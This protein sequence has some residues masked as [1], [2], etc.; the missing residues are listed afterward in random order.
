MQKFQIGIEPDTAIGQAPRRVLRWKTTLAVA[1]GVCIFIGSLFV[2]WR[3]I[4]T[5][6]YVETIQA[7]GQ[8]SFTTLAISFVLM[9]FGFGI[10]SFEDATGAP[11]PSRL[12]RSRRI[13]LAFVANAVSNITTM[14][15]LA[16]P[17]LRDRLFSAWSMTPLDLARLGQRNQLSIFMSG[18]ALLVLS[19]IVAQGE[20]S[21]ELKVNSFIVYVVCMILSATFV[22]ISRRRLS[23][24][25]PS[26][27]WVMSSSFGISLLLGLAKWL[28]AAGALYVCLGN[29]IGHSLSWF[30]AGFV[31]AHSLGRLSGLP[32]GIGVFEATCFV[33][34]V[35]TNPVDLMVA[36]IAY[37]GLYF[38]TPLI[39]SAVITGFMKARP[40]TGQVARGSTKVLDVFELIAPPLYAVLIF[41]TGG[42][43]LISAATP[44]SFAS[45]PFL[46]EGFSLAVTE[47]SHLTA[48]FIGSL[49]LIVAMGLRRRLKNAWS[50]A[51]IF[52]FAGAIFTLLKGADPK[53][54]FVLLVLCFSLFTSKGAFYR[55]GSI[56]DIPL[57]LPRLGV[58]LTTI[59]FAIWI[60]FFSYLDQPYK[61]DLWWQFG[62][63]SDVSR[64]FRA[65][66][67][68][69]TLFALYGFWRLLQPAPNLRRATSDDSLM[70]RIGA[71]L[72][73]AE[74]V[75]SDA[76]LA[77]MG[78]KQFLFSESGKSF[79]MYGVKGRTWVVMGNP[80]GLAAE[81]KELIW[82]FRQLADQ[83]DAWPCF[84]AVRGDDL[85]DFIDAGLALQ[86]IGEL[87]LIS[88][89]DF[90][91]EGKKRSELRNSK[92]RA[93][94]E[95][96]G[97]EI[98]YPA[99][100]SDDMD[101]LERISQNWLETHQGKEKQFS[102]GRFDRDVLSRQPVAVV[103]RAGEIIAFANLWTTH[104]KTEVSIDLMRYEDVKINGLMDYLFTEIILWAKAE[105]YARFSLGM[106]PLAGLEGDKLAPFMTKLGALIFEHG[107]RFYGFKGL[108]AFK[109]KFMPEW[110]PVYIAAPSQLTMP[111]A[112]GNL[113]LLSS[114][115]ILGLIQK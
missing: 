92:S 73:T 26:L 115:G 111:V 21:S 97:F 103:R 64:F 68:I 102:L 2:I 29:G 101:R 67:L 35:N 39:L 62:L 27:A 82:T 51:V 77:L 8:L 69:G 49:L 93:L 18:I 78:D 44:N 20:I 85:T 22:A 57:S 98:L 81:R 15:S 99:A 63:E 79:L 34:F 5:V 52:L 74:N 105:G 16:G 42:A 10:A 46:G 75:G 3:Q 114:G 87:A 43:M 104:C 6:S 96:C 53:G 55:K 108:R 38:F 109:Q 110:E 83:W 9:I 36:L 107:G 32:G 40:F 65:F 7:L 70:D 24:E 14:G 41:L 54:A 61:A 19:L 71:V 113:A 56:R 23:F 28:A 91:M 58:I 66:V 88:L 95:G 94:R 72:Q 47:F 112:L 25:E 50:L 80:V 60:G 86:K 13:A 4:Q 59:G 33:L 37:R 12:S 31:I 100:D 45:L 17:D 90:T 76:N 11:E 30:L 106:A 1:L 89:N 84:Y 48:S